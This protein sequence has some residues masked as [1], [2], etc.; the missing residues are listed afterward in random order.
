MSRSFDRNIERL[1]A[2]QA[3]ISRQ[4]QGITTA[5]ARER[6]EYEIAHVK[7]IRNKLTPFSKELQA[8]KERDIK[9]KTAEGV[10]AA[11]KARL[12]KAKWLNENGSETAKRLY[13]IEQAK[14]M[15]ELAFEF[16]DAKAQDLEYHRLK[17]ILLKQG[18]SAAYPDADRLAQL[19]PWQQVGFAQEQIRMKM[20]GFED[21][22][23]HSMQNGTEPISLGGITYTA[24]EIKDNALAFP[25][26]QAA[27]EVYSDKIYNNLGLD[28]YSDEMLKMSGVQDTI[29]KAKESQLTKY[30]EQYNIESS[31]GT[32]KK[33]ELEWKRSD[34]TAVDLQHLLVKT[35]NTVSTDGELLGR[36]GGWKQVEG[37]IVNEGIEL[38][39]PDYAETILNQP[40]P[41]SMARELGVKP[42]KTFAEHWPGKLKDMKAKIKK[43]YVDEVNAE[44]DYLQAAGTDLTNDFI[45]EARE[46]PAG[47]TTARVNEIKRQYGELGLT[48]PSA[49]TNY[50]TASMRDQRE[51]SDLIKAL[52]ASQ[53]G[54]ISN[55]QLDAFHPEAALEYRDKATKLEE[56]AVKKHGAEAKIKAHLNVAFTNMGIKANEKSPA[57]VEALENAK[58]DYANK[59]NS[60][61]AMGYSSRE[62]SHHALHSQQV[63][64]KETGELIPDSM[65]VLTEIR[66]NQENSKY[67][68]TGQ[69]VEKDLKPGHIRVARIHGAKEE[70]LNDPKIVTNGIVG[71][72]YGHR[73]ITSIKNNIEKH[74]IRGL[75][76]DKGAL[77]YYKGI[78]RGRNAREGGWWALVDAQLKAAGHEGL[79]TLGRPAIMDYTTGKDKDGNI[80][81]DPNGSS[82]INKQVSSALQYPSTTNFLYAMNQV[83]D[84]ERGLTG[85][86]SV[87]DEE[88]QLLP[89]VI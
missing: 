72:D 61:I 70:I 5:A 66:T 18:G 87:W 39:N 52:M 67:V 43:G 22:L 47:L 15:G 10:A 23:A 6:G 50:E 8:W 48:I 16:E 37:I 81:P 75:Y 38:Q 79:N 69:S 55:E 31:M 86:R 33:A 44:E 58:V 57:W 25:M 28:R 42:G 7:D 13:A 12:D 64:N 45:K 4:E 17:E 53:N 21:Q 19:S 32:R 1:K 34:K 71:G 84:Q 40:M 77:Q 20:L 56:G 74:G 76:M 51:D 60:Y 35:S 73:Q 11:R 78:T 3:Q 65:G 59:Y 24:A 82:R 14:A 85:L 89:W 36:A 41:A 68:I 27:I 49:V 54:Y 29:Q 2:N 83:N 30:R 88:N 62:A 80:L 9:K 46:N 26:K 63:T